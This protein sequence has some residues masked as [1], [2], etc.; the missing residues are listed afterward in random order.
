MAGDRPTRLDEFCNQYGLTFFELKIPCTFCKFVLE[1]QEL[2]DFYTK[3]LSLIWKGPECFAACRRCI[4]LSA[5]YELDHFCRC[6]VRAEN[7]P[8][9]LGVCIRN[10]TIR[11]KVCYK[12][13]DY[14][15][16]VDLLAADESY[17]LVRHYWRGICR[18]C[19]KK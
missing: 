15:E 17:V 19:R 13:L 9:L 12:K 11:C 2:A 3:G 5:K 14:A 18:N 8:D 16:K 7:L 6:R 1:L 4:L 10:L